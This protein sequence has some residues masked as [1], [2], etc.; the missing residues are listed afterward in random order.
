[1]EYNQI[2]GQPLQARMWMSDEETQPLPTLRGLAFRAFLVKY[3]LLLRDVALEADVRLLTVW[4]ITRD[5]PISRRQ[6]EKVRAALCRLTGA[7]Y[8][9]RIALRLEQTGPEINGRAVF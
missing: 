8:R 5:L 1:M 6:A 7:H 4:N 9:G 3:G 2:F